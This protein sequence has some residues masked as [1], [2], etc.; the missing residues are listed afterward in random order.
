GIPPE[1]TEKLQIDEEL[2]AERLS[3]DVHYQR[4]SARDK[5]VESLSA[6]FRLRKGKDFSS[7]EDSPVIFVTTNTLLAQ[8]SYRFFNRSEYTFKS[9]LCVAA[10]LLTNLLWLKNPNRL[11]DLPKKQLIA[12]SYAA[13]EPGQDLWKKYLEE[14]E[15]LKPIE[16]LSEED[17]I[18]LRYSIEAKNVLMSLTW[19]DH[20]RLKPA[21]VTEVL[22]K[23]KTSIQ[24]PERDKYDE[25]VRKHFET[26]EKL[27][28][29][30]AKYL[31]KDQ[32]L[33]MYSERIGVLC[34]RLVLGLIGLVLTIGTIASLPAISPLNISGWW[35]Y[36]ISFFQLAFL[37]LGS[38]SLFNGTT[39]LSIGR[40][41]ELVISS[42]IL[43]IRRWKERGERGFH[44]Q[45][46]V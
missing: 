11:A 8:S 30:E 1:G 22:D 39:A 16:G 19:G 4:D 45:N 21:M 15:R 5:D 28:T 13:L 44:S 42:K 32:K 18:L 26:K 9:P 35:Y 25:E 40:R 37:M 38:I 17:Y 3:Q 34:S 2:L 31:A 20:N 14:I 7:I 33:Q 41:I 6:I 27:R 24:K 23:V 29:S 12:M 10:P 46:Q 36:F 43:T